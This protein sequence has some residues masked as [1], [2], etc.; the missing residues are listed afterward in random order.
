MAKDRRGQTPQKEVTKGQFIAR[1]A[2][3]GVI[4]LVGIVLIVVACATM[5]SNVAN[6]MKKDDDTTA[7][8]VYHG[9]TTTTL[10]TTVTTVPAVT[11]TT[12]TDT[13]STTDVT[14]TTTEVTTTTE[15]TTTT[16][17]TTTTTTTQTQPTSA[18]TQVD[19]HF[20]ASNGTE[21][22][23][24]LVNAWNQMTQAESETLPITYISDIEA[25]DSRIVEPLQQ[26]LSDAGHGLY[27]TSSYRSY[28]TQERLYNNK[29]DRVMAANSSLSYDEAARIAATEVARPGT[30]EH[31]TGLAVDLLYEGQYS[32]EQDWEDG[33][34]FDW[35][36]A[37]CH[38]Y[39]FILRFPEGKE[40][41]TGVIYEP[42]HYRYVGKD[43][44]SEIMAR[45]ITLE[46]YLQ[47]Q[48]GG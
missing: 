17:Q 38:E 35:L 14:T 24:R 32:L 28:A 36:M 34:V 46:E 40:G 21:W 27:V 19:G 25:V 30:S 1:I 31:N 5:A 39:G 18:P 10:S 26:M 20:V 41:V 33:E 16:T 45:G 29:V 43:A 47:E 13:T 3:A 42:W 8:T 44:A 7:T 11:T 15:E 4:T 22:N 23:L 2:I 48:Q 12:V 6:S 9:A 37:H